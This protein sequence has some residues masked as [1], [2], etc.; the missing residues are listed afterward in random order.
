MDRLPEKPHNAQEV[1]RAAL[2]LLRER[3]PADWDVRED[4]AG[5]GPSDLLLHLRSPDRVETA[6]IVAA[7][8]TLESRDV[9][10]VSAQLA[11]AVGAAPGSTGMVVARYLASS[12]RERLAGAGLSYADASG[13]IRVRIDRPA[14]F[15]SDRGVDKDPWRGPGRP[16][17]TLNGAPAARVVRAL[18]DFPDPWRIRRLVNVAGAS[19]GSVYRVVDFLESESIVTR[20]PGGEL[21]VPDWAALLR[22]WSQDY[23]FARANTV[24]RWVAPRGIENF[25]GR[26]RDGSDEG[27]AMTGSVAANFWAPYA[28]ARSAMVYTAS[29]RQAAEEWGLRE[30]DTGANV[31]LAEPVFEVQVE[32]TMMVDGLVLAAPTQVAADLLTGPGRSPSEAEA[33]IEWADRS[34]D[35]AAWKVRNERSRT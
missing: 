8:T 14:L 9:A 19:T 25:L 27:Y 28:P 5:R 24:T 33:L 4:R 26:V 35:F 32:R 10:T 13:N 17:G 29:P 12:V 7:R 1:L 3:L 16:R 21:V 30:T 34:P 2:S 18:L 6:V 15:V 20:S 22:R 23:Q 11:D 31:V